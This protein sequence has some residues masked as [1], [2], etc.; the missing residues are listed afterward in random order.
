[1]NTL[2]NTNLQPKVYVGTYK[3]YNEGSIKGGW[4]TLTDYKDYGAFCTACRAL[5]KDERDPELM[6]Q[7]CSDMP[8]GLSVM[9]WLSEQE[10][11]DIIEACHAEEMPED[12]PKFQLIDYSEKAIALVGDTRDIKEQLKQ[13][14]GRFNPRLSCGCGWIFPKSKRDE[15]EKLIQ[16]GT[17]ESVKGEKIDTKSDSGAIYKQTLAEWYAIYKDDYY[18]KNSIGAIKLNDGYLLLGK[19]SIE[20]KFCFHDEGP[21]YE[22]YLKVTKTEESLKKY[23]LSENLGGLDREIKD[24]SDEDTVFYVSDLNDGR[25]SYYCHRNYWHFREREEHVELTPEQRAELIKALQWSRGEFEKRLNT[26]LKRYGT[27]KI[28]TWTYWAD[29]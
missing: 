23:F 8:D 22:F 18:K 27:S 2:T 16:G 26:Y 29:A 17:V 20:T 24:L 1:M 9:E 10:F 5:H 28:H 6:I 21:D 14:G 13:L 3:K 7:D 4:L 25:K 15:V 19:E 11:N 12:A